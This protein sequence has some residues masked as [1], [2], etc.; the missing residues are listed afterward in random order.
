MVSGRVSD[1]VGSRNETKGETDFTIC[2]PGADRHGLQ[3]AD[4]VQSAHYVLALQSMT[5]NGVL[6]GNADNSQFGRPGEGIASCRSGPAWPVHGRRGASDTT[7]RVGGH[8]KHDWFWQPRPSTLCES[9]RRGSVATGSHRTAPGCR[10][11][12]MIILD[13]NVLSEL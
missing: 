6:N 7:E 13:T 8:C 1:M 11:S 10:V 2:R 4:N 5:A 3:P 9:R 12:G